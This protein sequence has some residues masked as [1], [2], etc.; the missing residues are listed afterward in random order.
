MKADKLR[1]DTTE[2]HLGIALAFVIISIFGIQAVLGLTDSATMILDGELRGPDSYMRLNRVVQLWQSGDWLDPV[3]HRIFAPFGHVQHWTRPMDLLLLAG[4]IV[5]APFVGFATA[6]HGWAVLV[7]PVLHAACLLVTVWAASAIVA[8]RSL[9][10]VAFLFILQP[11]LFNAFMIARPDHQGLIVL[12]ATGLVGLTLHLLKG[13]H[14][15]GLAL[16][17]GVVAGF[18][19]WISVETLIV[20]LISI[21]A[22]AV[23]WLIADRSAARTLVQQ[24]VALL[25]TLFLALVIERG[26][27]GFAN[28]EYDMISMAHLGLFAINC[29]AWIILASLT[30]TSHQ[31]SSMGARLVVSGTLALIGGGALALVFPGFFSSPLDQVD[32]LYRA[33]RLVNIREIQPMIGATA[34]AVNGLSTEI[35]RAIMWMGQA[36]VALVWAVWLLIRAARD[37]GDPSGLCQWFYLGLGL[38]IFVAMTF[39][40]VRW[41]PYA[42]LFALLVYGHFAVWAIDAVARRLDARRLTLVRPFLVVGLSLW[43]YVPLVFMSAQFEAAVANVAAAHCKLRAATDFLAAP[44]GLGAT[45]RRVLAFVDSGPEILYRTPHSVLSIPNHRPQPGFNLSY[46]A[47]TA[48]DFA[49][50]ETLLR[51]AGVELALVCRATAPRGFYAS[52]ADY[53]PATDTPTLHEALIAGRPPA[54]LTEIDLPGGAAARLRLYAVAPGSAP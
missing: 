2:G 30:A 16:A 27:Q 15:P 13:P 42:G 53:D 29:L 52:R 41:S 24:S 48:T 35:A 14:R 6:L 25:G 26:E 32:P 37:R 23:R 46:R 8:R 44:N 1:Q 33:T 43:S 31:S 54:Y 49:A 34:I 17:S 45:Q 3:Y 47:M 4:G 51:D 40:Q 10:V 38:A 21:A 19:V 20:V 36:A 18:A 5:G 28:I 22:L 9:W 39:A 7:N 50:A 11:G 12:T